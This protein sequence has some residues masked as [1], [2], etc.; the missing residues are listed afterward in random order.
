MDPIHSYSCLLGFIS[1]LDG[2]VGKSAILPLTRLV[3]YT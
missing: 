1:N 2:L 3:K